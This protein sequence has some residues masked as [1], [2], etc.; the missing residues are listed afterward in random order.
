MRDGLYGRLE[1]EMILFGGYEET[2]EGERRVMGPNDD[3]NSESIDDH[4]AAAHV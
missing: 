3:W 4:I 1:Q 2:E